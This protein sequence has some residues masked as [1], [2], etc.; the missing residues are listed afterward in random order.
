M[1]SSE[2]EVIAGHQG[3]ELQSGWHR[4]LHLL[5]R[6]VDAGVHLRGISTWSREHHADGTWF[7]LDVGCEVVAH[8]TYLHLCYIAQV[9]DAAATGTQHDVVELF[10]GLQR[11]LVLHGV[12]VGVLRLFTQGTHTSYEALS[13]DSSEDIVRRQTVL[14]HHIGLQPDAQGVR[15]T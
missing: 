14:G 12:L 4:C 9:Q 2:Q 3:Y 10:D 5:K 6:F 1:D 13:T 15:V 7:V 8:G 11:T